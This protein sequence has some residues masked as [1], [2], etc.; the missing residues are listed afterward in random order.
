MNTLLLM[1]GGSGT[2]MGAARPKQ[3][4][5]IKGKPVFW[6][7]VKGY[8]D[9][10]EIDAICIVSHADWIPYVRDAIKDIAFGGKLLIAPG[11]DNR[12][13][14][15]RNGLR[16]IEGFSGEDDVVMMHDATHPYV[17]REGTAEV[18]RAVKAYGGATLGARQYD[19][20]YRMDE[21]LMLTNVIPRQEIVS[22]ASP[23]AFRFEDMKR[24]YFEASD[25]EL[26][27]MTSAG[28]IALAHHIP[29]KVVP[30]KILNL[31]LTYPEDLELFRIL[32]DEYFISGK[33]L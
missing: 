4:I 25:E 18:I 24:I 26:A 14:S 2:R 16:A 31:K 23:E 29:M 27:S 22:G 3:F 9:V 20:C 12:S 11:G 19:T 33:R 10:A 1:M 28:A 30:S 21:D 6:Y 13:Q 17:D 5:E 7:I 32:L 15:I 8:A